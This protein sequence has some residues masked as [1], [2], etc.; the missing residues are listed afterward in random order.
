MPSLISEL[1]RRNVFRVGAAYVLVAWLVAQAGDLL[2]DN[3][4][5]PDWF[6]P[7]LL[8]MLALGL[9]IALFLA[10]AFELTPQG[11]K[12]TEEVDR[13]ASITPSTGRRLNYFIIAALALAVVLL[14]ADRFREP[15]AATESIRDGGNVVTSLEKSIAVLPF[16]NLST[17]T[18]ADSFV[19]G[20]HDDLLTQL[21]KINDLKVISRT[22]V[23]R[24]ADT[25][26]NI[27]DIGAELGV[28]TVMEGGVQRAGDR[29]RLNVQLIDSATDEHIWA[30]TYDRV[31]TTAN[32]FDV[33]S[34]I[35]RQ[36]ATALQAALTPAEQVSLESRPTDSLTAYEAYLDARLLLKQRDDRGDEVLTE[37][38][39]MARKSVELDP[40]FAEAWATLAHAYLSRFWYTSR[41]QGDASEAWASIDRAR[42]L[43]P[44]ST[45]VGLMLGLYHYWVNLDYASALV[46]VDRVLTLESS[47]EHAWAIRGWI[48]RRAGRWSEA[49]EALKRAAV[50]DPN[51]VE[52]LV[53]VEDSLR[54]LDRFQE[55]AAWQDA[56]EK[57]E[58]ENPQIRLRRAW[59]R[60]ATTGDSRPLLTLQRELVDKGNIGVVERVEYVLA[61]ARFGDAQRALDFIG[62]WSPG[63]IDV[64]YH[65]WP[66]DLLR[67]YVLWNH[68]ESTEAARFAARALPI[69]DAAQR[70]E[71]NE[72]DIER[73]RAYALAIMGRKDEALAAAQRVRELYPRS[74]DDWGGGDYLFAA[75]E[76]LAIA[77]QDELALKWLDEYESG[78]GADFSLASTRQYPAYARLADSPGFLALV[79]KHGLVP[80]DKSRAQ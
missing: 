71:P 15:T 45:A 80:T 14:L 47:N 73:A 68:G 60:Q 2:A 74:L 5:F 9:P 26:H 3:L 23:L 66:E 10:W 35:T 64:Q 69:I 43:Q 1:K 77:G 51:S 31:L 8:A 20:L 12:K 37:A 52:N 22:S 58:P 78:N 70:I 34:E 42:E 24:Y 75:A 4:S 40:G 33:Q 6:M 54:V 19:A 59:L 44:D 36:I 79:E 57:R 62:Q 17:D 63:T 16:S 67:A 56:A 30:E 72:A 28:A 50:L 25:V 65:L 49:L 18:S 55:A 27:R 41:E 48:L 21:S 32:V 7:M 76:T 38:I 13:D 29:V 61:E 46:E 39:D 53:E 11:V